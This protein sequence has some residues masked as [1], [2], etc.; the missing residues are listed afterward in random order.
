MLGAG[1]ELTTLSRDGRP[2]AELLDQALCSGAASL[3]LQ[4]PSA[5][6][7]AQLWG[8]AEGAGGGGAEA[9]LVDARQLR[10]WYDK[11]SLLWGQRW[12]QGFVDGLRSS[13]VVVPVLSRDGLAPFAAL[14]SDSRCD[15][16]LLEHRIVL[17][18]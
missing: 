3:P 11:K 12:E 2:A 5:A 15:N 16:V 8:C 13:L 6:E 17:A 4:L 14:R 18:K 1:G 9:S 10:V 7:V